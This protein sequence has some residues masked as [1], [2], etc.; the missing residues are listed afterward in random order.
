[1][2]AEELRYW[3]TVFEDNQGCFDLEYND[4]HDTQLKVLDGLRMA[5]EKVVRAYS[6]AL[7]QSQVEKVEL[8]LRTAN[9]TETSPIL[10]DF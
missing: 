1:M 8:A 10:P 4:S 9:E 2:V 7:I 5:R 3:S 6:K